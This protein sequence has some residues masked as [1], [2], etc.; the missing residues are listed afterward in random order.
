MVMVM[1][2]VVLVVVGGNL[3]LGVAASRIEG[4]VGRVARVLEV[5]GRHR[6]GRAAEW[7]PE[8]T[9]DS[10]AFGWVWVCVIIQ[11]ASEVTADSVAFNC[12]C[13]CVCVSVC[14]KA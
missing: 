8:A 7:H 12:V 13:V 9:A 10:F 14:V 5:V 4:A 3:R 6:L 1:V 2:M 11:D